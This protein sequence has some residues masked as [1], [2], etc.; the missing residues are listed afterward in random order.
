MNNVAELLRLI[1]N[2]IRIGTIAEVDHGNPDLDPLRPPRVRVTL[3]DIKTG[4]L[5]WL[6]AHAGTTRTWC[7]PTVDEQ[8]I[9]FSPGGDL[10]AGVV[11]AGLFRERHPAPS[12]NEDLFKAVMP[13]GAV[14]EYHHTDHHLSA[15]IPGNADIRA[16][17]GLVIHADTTIHGRLTI[18][19]ESVQHNGTDIGNMHTHR[20]V[21]SGSGTSGV[22]N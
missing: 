13:D 4:W 16:V 21:T 14:I 20:G 5:P 12:N 15:E 17:K 3:G 22:P 19:G 7:P 8:V 6:A 2:L 1:H 11:L 10:N 18:N 9:V